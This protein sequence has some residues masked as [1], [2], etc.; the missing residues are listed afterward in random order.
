MNDTWS[1]GTAVSE[2]R[3][4]IKNLDG[5][6]QANAIRQA[7]QQA[8]YAGLNK[9]TTPRITSIRDMPWILNNDYDIIPIN[10]TTRDFQ[11]GQRVAYRDIQG[12]LEDKTSRY[13]LV[14]CSPTVREFTPEKLPAI[15]EAS[16]RACS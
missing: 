9:L 14:N 1:L 7:L 5:R 8:Y 4:R 16:Q 10:A 12:V 13:F 3:E 6:E 2:L 15:W 11:L